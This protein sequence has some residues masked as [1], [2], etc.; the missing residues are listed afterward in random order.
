MTLI[1][2]ECVKRK[3]TIYVSRIRFGFHDSLFKNVKIIV[4]RIVI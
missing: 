3:K 4:R 1:K 2:N